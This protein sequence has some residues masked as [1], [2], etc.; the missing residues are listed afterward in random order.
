MGFG[1]R[2]RHEAAEKVEREKAEKAAAVEKAKAEKAK[3][4][5][6]KAERERIAAIVR[7]EQ[8]KQGV[9]G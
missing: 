5:A 4:D 1:S 7:E 9:R 6:D 8:A 3:A 2:S